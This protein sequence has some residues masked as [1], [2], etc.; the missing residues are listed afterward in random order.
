MLRRLAWLVALPLCFGQAAADT[1]M[2]LDE[3]EEHGC[4]P[5]G[6]SDPGFV[7][8]VEGTEAP[9]RTWYPAGSVPVFSAALSPRPFE[10][11]HAR[12]PPVS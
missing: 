1:H 11:G 10:V 7:L 12:A 3:V 2:H 5:C 4:T 8:D 9:P 6:F